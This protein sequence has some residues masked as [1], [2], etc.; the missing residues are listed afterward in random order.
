MT[1]FFY[2]GVRPV[3]ARHETALQA[4]NTLKAQSVESTDPQHFTC[5]G[6][7]IQALFYTTSGGKGALLL[8][9]S[10]DGERLPHLDATYQKRSFLESATPIV[11][12]SQALSVYNNLSSIVDVEKEKT[13]AGNAK[14]IV[15]ETDGYRFKRLNPARLP[16]FKEAYKESEIINRM[17]NGSEYSSRRIAPPPKETFG[18]VLFG[19]IGNLLSDLTGR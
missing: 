18:T 5:P 15:E 19:H 16:T 2:E 1:S 11:N 12:Y 9:Y 7:G 17:P 10:K 4:S 3:A 13:K 6:N 14:R 8:V